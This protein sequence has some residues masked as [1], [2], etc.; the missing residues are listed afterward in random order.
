SEGVVY[1]NPLAVDAAEVRDHVQRATGAMGMVIDVR[2]YP[3]A[4]GG[5]A[6]ATHLVTAPSE[7]FLLSKADPANPGAFGF[8]PPSTIF[9]AAPHYHGRVA[10]LVDESTQ[11][12]AETIGMMLRTVPGAVVVGSR[13]A[14]ANGN[15]S[16][17]PLPGGLRGRISGI[18]VF[19][20]DRSPTQRIGIIPDIVATPT[21]EGIRQGRDEVLE[22]ALRHIYGDDADE[23]A[24]RR[25]A[26]RPD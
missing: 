14:A 3:S 7:F 23:D 17:F 21:I 9:P 26:L 19:Y 2:S 4:S 24:I 11:S 25:M 12:A 5:F 15:V 13:T 16:D 6:L 22:A 8:A 1:L 18:G 10:I 20:P